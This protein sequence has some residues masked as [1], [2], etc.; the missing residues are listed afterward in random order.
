[1]L[2]ALECMAKKG[3]TDDEIAEAL[4]VTDRTVD[5]WKKQY[6]EFFRSLKT[7]KD[8][9]DKKVERSLYD[10]ARGYRMKT[11]KLFCE[12]KTGRI[13]RAESYEK[14][15]PDPTSMIF[16]LKNRKPKE[17]RDKQDID[18]NVQK[19]AAIIAEEGDDD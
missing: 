7:W 14:F 2:K 4:S 11:E 16:W 15:P 19:R 12:A 10:R 18:L 9:A 3:C 5:N 8:E 1:M 17:W 6:P 13:T